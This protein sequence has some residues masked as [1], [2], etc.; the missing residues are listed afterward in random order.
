[1]FARSWFGSRMFRL[2]QTKQEHF[3][4]TITFR[5]IC[6]GTDMSD[7]LP[8][9]SGIV[10]VERVVVLA[11]SLPVQRAVRCTWWPPDIQILVLRG[12]WTLS[13]LG[14]PAPM[15]SAATN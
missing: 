7:A 10:L 14:T 9:G 13:T 5:N 3:A 15:L 4:L 8:E 6:Q 11:G 12:L 1:M 2:G